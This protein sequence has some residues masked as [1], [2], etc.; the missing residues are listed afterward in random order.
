MSLK[1]TAPALGQAMRMQ[2]GFQA[3]SET[4]GSKTEIEKSFFLGKPIEYKQ[5]KGSR[6]DSP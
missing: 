5:A 6:I 3:I 2:M 4:R 1:L